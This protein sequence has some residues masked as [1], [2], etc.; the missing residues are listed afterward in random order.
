MCVEKNKIGLIGSMYF[1]GWFATTLIIPPLA[2]KIGRKW[3]SFVSIVV[4]SFTMIVVLFSRSVDL[5]IAM[6][7][8]MGACCPGRASVS[9]VYLNEFLTPKWRI[10]W[11]TAW[12]LIDG[13]T[14]IILTFYF[15]FLSNRYFYISS[16]GVI[17]AILSA[18]GILVAMPE[19]PL[20]Q[21]MTGR[22]EK[23]HLTL[24][25][26]M[27]MNGVIVPDDEILAL[28]E[29]PNLSPTRVNHT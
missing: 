8:L 16:V 17:W 21:M 6:F 23:G 18:I 12:G 28:K 22:F 25:K 3:I 26:I 29:D 20:W 10:A 24:K 15:D 14:Y 19:S 9:Y 11:G 27:R 4:T 13:S 7:F 2:D 1:A 5:T